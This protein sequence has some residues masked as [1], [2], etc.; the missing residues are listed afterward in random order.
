MTHTVYTLA[1]GKSKAW[2]AI[3]REGSYKP[4]AE[5][6][7]GFGFN[8]KGPAGEW[9]TKMSE[10]S[11]VTLGYAVLFEEGFDFVKGGKLPG[12]FGGEGEKALKC[13]GGRQTDRCSCFNLR[14]MW[15]YVLAVIFVQTTTLQPSTGGKAE[16]YMYLPV[17]ESNTR[18]LIAVPGSYEDPNYGFS[19]GRGCHTFTPGK[20]A[21]ISERVKLND[22]GEENGE[23]ELWIDGVSVLNVDG[24]VLRTSDKSLIQGLHFETFFGG[25]TSVLRNYT[26][27]HMILCVPLIGSTPDWAS[28]RDQRAWFSSVSGA[29]IA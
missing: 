26:P 27:S 20:W 19:V 17:C 13:S 18:R 1:D 24:L 9:R 3:Y 29:V 10:A 25:K 7:G 12:I 22:V 14:L 2:E 5:I 4:S 6:K 16:I 23:V 8:L 28:P 11:E 21:V 15:R